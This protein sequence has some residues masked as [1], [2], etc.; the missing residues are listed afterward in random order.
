VPFTRDLLRRLRGAWKGSLSE[1]SGFLEKGFTPACSSYPF[2]F[3][4]NRLCPSAFVLLCAPL[5]S[6]SSALHPRRRRRHDFTRPSQPLSVRGSAQPGAWPAWVERAGARRKNPRRCRPPRQS[7]RRGVHFV[8]LL[9]LLQV[10]AADLTILPAAAGGVRAS[11]PAPHAPLHPPGGHLRPPLRD[12][13]R[14]GS[15]HF[16]LPPLLRVGQVWEDQGPHRGL[17]LLD[18]ARSGHRLHPH[19]WWSEVGELAKRLGDR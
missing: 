14:G 19:P 6:R 5:H 18:K 17:L 13:H 7:R 11:G 1:D 3:S 2:A 10:G 16:S 4:S 8:H 9:H 12:V 15:L